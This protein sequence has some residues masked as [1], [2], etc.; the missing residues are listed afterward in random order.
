MGEW[1]GQFVVGVCAAG[2]PVHA[3]DLVAMCR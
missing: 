2:D 1:H 3:L